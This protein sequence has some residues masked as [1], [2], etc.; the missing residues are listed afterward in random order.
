MGVLL[1]LYPVAVLCSKMGDNTDFKKV[2]VEIWTSFNT[3]HT[4]NNIDTINW[5]VEKGLKTN[6]LDTDLVVDFGCGTGE[7]VNKCAGLGVFGSAH[8]LG[9]DTNL[10]FIQH[11]SNQAR[12]RH[13]ASFFWS[14]YH[15]DMEF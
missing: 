5:A 4:K 2:G 11:A 10:S 12:K 1:R 3:L 13:N 7:V 8:I 9:L 15:E 6:L 14:E